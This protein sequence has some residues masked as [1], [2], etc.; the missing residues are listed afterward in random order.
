VSKHGY[1]GCQCL[2]ELLHEYFDALSRPGTPLKTFR[3]KIFIFPAL[4]TG[5]EVALA[6]PAADAEDM[7]AR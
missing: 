4:Q 5:Y 3:I 2:Q 1:D 6:D 7:E